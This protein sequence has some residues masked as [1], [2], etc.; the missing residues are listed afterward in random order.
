M[1]EKKGTGNNLPREER[2]R[3]DTTDA[4]DETEQL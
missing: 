4:D 2:K 1:V 3:L